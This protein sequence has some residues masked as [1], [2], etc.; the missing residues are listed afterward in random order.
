VAQG[1]VK[2]KVEFTDETT[3]GLLYYQENEIREYSLRIGGEFEHQT[4]AHGGK[5]RGEAKSGLSCFYD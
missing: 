5:K 2:V 4:D 1:R 3:T